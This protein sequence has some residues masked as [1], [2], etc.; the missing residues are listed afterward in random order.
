MDIQYRLIK[1]ID[2]LPVPHSIC[3]TLAA[4]IRF[5]LVERQE[6]PIR[7]KNFTPLTV[8]LCDKLFSFI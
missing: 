5:F 3:S 6:K 1:M 4:D 8:W 2:A 7:G